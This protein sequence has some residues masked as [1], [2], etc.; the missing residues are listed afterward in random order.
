[1]Q[2]FIV[3]LN[4]HVES[5]REYIAKVGRGQEE[6]AKAVSVKVFWNLIDSSLGDKNY[7][8]LTEARRDTGF[9][10]YRHC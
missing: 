3:H 10:T 8:Y 2:S 5:W 4:Y 1:M 9:A 6:T 7:A